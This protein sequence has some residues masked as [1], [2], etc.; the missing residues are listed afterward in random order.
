MVEPIRMGVL[1]SGTG[2]HLANFM[3]LS[4]AGELPARM[5][6]VVSTRS[7]VLGVTVARE[8]GLPLEVVPPGEGFDRRVAAALTARDA[9]LVCM[10]GFL[11]LWRFPPA[12]AGR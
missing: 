5:V 12:F 6:V 3:R 11:W 7:D 10:A 9:Q 1:I 8:A 4:E 2:R